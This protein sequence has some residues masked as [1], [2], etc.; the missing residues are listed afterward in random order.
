MSA[1]ASLRHRLFGG[2]QGLQRVGTRHG[3]DVVA[4]VH[5]VDFAGHTAR[6]L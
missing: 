3:D 6:K 5:I 1:I 4:G 2:V